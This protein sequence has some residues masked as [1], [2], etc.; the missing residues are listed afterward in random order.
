MMKPHSPNSR[1]PLLL[2]IAVVVAL[3]AVVTTVGR[4][5]LRGRATGADENG[6]SGCGG[7]PGEQVTHTS[8][9]VTADQLNIGIVVNDAAN[10]TVSRDP[11]VTSFPIPFARDTNV[12]SLNSLAVFDDA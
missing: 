8:A 4:S 12:L 2:R 9:A 5:R 3:G 1:R 7:A 6:Q 10:A 11:Q